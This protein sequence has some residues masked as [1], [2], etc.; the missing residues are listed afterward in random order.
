M[1]IHIKSRLRWKEY[2]AKKDVGVNRQ[3][4]AYDLV[5]ELKSLKQETEDRWSVEWTFHNSGN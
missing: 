3:G 2:G 5:E 4:R 1:L